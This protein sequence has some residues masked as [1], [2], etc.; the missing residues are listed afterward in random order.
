[1]PLMTRLFASGTT[2]VR[3]RFFCL[4]ASSANVR[5]QHKILS[6]K[7]RQRG[8]T[9]T[10][11]GVRTAV[12]LQLPAKCL[13]LP[14]N[15]RLTHRVGRYHH[16]HR[17]K[18]VQDN[19]VLQRTFGGKSWTFT[20]FAYLIFEDERNGMVAQ[21]KPLPSNE[22]VWK[23]EN[24][25]VAVSRF[26]AYSVCAHQQL[27][28]SRVR[29]SWP[30]NPLNNDLNGQGILPSAEPMPLHPYGICASGY[31]SGRLIGKSK[32]CLYLLCS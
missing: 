11:P 10:S 21:W 31:V 26:V 22:R 15:N 23:S 25:R 29:S 27:F 7:S 3:P 32:D 18:A 24:I 17:Y 6:R 12:R 16:P 14:S 20:D 19:Q 13:P 28:L 9:S 4:F 30:V 2:D 5:L 1:V 8:R